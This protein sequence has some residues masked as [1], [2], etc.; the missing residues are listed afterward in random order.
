MQINAFINQS[1][2]PAITGTNDKTIVSTLSHDGETRAGPCVR[3]RVLIE[4]TTTGSHSLGHVQDQRL[5]TGDDAMGPPSTHISSD[6]QHICGAATRTWSDLNKTDTSFMF[7]LDTDNHFLSSYFYE[8]RCYGSFKSTID[9]FYWLGTSYLAVCHIIAKMI[10][11][12][13]F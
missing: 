10:L 12:Y 9:I 4:S 13:V 7:C 11:S 1:I 8:D 2:F 6:A 3:Q 5:R